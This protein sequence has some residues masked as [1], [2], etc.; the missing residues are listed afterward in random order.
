MGH[1]AQAHCIADFQSFA[2]MTPRE[3]IAA[4]KAVFLDVG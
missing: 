3:F 2:G 4:K 1:Y